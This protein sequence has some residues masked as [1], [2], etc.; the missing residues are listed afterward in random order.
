MEPG[1]EDRLHGADPVM[2]YSK[3]FMQII[4]GTFKI[5]ASLRFHQRE[6]WLF[7][8]FFSIVLSVNGRAQPFSSYFD[9]QEMV[10]DSSQQIADRIVQ[11]EIPVLVDFWA[12][13]CAPCR[14]ISPIIAKLEKT[15]HGRVLFMK[16]NVDYNRQIAAYFQIQGIPAVFIIRD[17]AVKRALVGVR[18]DADY[19]KAIEEVLA[20]RPADTAKPDTAKKQDTVKKRDSG[21]AKKTGKMKAERP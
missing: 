3:K 13:W 4:T 19:R 15:Y 17:K 11:S 21:K 8:A 20:M 2:R 6:S 14:M 10:P 7:A 16:V 5:T 9:G 12:V 18:R 1:V